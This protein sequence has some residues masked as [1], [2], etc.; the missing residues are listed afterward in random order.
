VYY[1]RKPPV[2]RARPVADTPRMDQVSRPMLIVLAATF[3]LLA[4]WLV[5]LK[6]KQL[7]VKSTPLAATKA[8]PKAEQAAAAADAANARS[9][10]PDN[11]ADGAAAAPDAAK[12]RVDPTTQNHPAP[13]S[14][15]SRVAGAKAADR[16]DAAVLRDLRAKKVV[17][18]LFWNANGADDIATRG[19]IR[20]LDRRNGKVAVHAA[21]IGRVGQYDSLTRGVH[22]V[23]SPTTI[24]IDRKRRTRVITGLTEPQELE[25]VVGDA[26]AGR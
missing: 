10:A 9:Q 6:P 5:A 21:P 20:E 1:T 2:T 23:Q 24:V 25:Q 14:V 13:S 18:M 11:A 26:L 12:A 17:V 4:I 3:A 7:D 22:V 15:A 8:I 16:R 19:V